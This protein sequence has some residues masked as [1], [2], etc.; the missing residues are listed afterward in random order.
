MR[1]L[2]RILQHGAAALSLLLCVA[3]VALWVRS[4]W[5]SDAIHWW[6]PTRRVYYS[7][8]SA[9]GRVACQS[10]EPRDARLATGP[11]RPGHAGYDTIPLPNEDWEDGWGVP[12]DARRTFMGFGYVRATRGLGRLSTQMGIVPMWFVT[13]LT[14]LPPAVHAFRLRRHRR[15]K[16]VCL[17]C[18]YDLRA[19][20]DRCPECGTVPTAQPAR[21]GGAGG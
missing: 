18:G 21:P 19:T 3:T 2:V 15:A 1:R 13:L 20:P 17:R 5:V 4:Y 7:V 8:A 9:R 10:D 14:A 16:G 11:Y 6:H 12:F